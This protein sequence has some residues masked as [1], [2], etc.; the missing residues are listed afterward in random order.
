MYRVK[1]HVSAVTAVTDYA[2]CCWAFSAGG[3]PSRLTH[4]T[5]FNH[6]TQAKYPPN[7]RNPKT[8]QTIIATV[9]LCTVKPEYCTRALMY[10]GYS[11]V[12]PLSTTDTVI[13]SDGPQKGVHV[14][15]V[16]LSRKLSGHT[17][18]LT[19]GHVRSGDRMREDQRHAD[20]IQLLLFVRPIH[21][22]IQV[23]M[24]IES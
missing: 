9:Q 22:H 12:F 24:T 11:I 15:G 16:M 18:F 5:E 20:R 17:L 4:T 23:G 21:L 19:T 10:H 8:R 3:K 6:R 13:F 14:R 1:L 7:L 2:F